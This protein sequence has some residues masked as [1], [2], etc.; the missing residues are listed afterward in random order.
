MEDGI[1]AAAVAV[2]GQL[3]LPRQAR[4]DLARPRE[5]SGMAVDVEPRLE[6][7]H[8]RVPVGIAQA[9][10]GVLAVGPAVGQLVG[11]IEGT[12]L[13]LEFR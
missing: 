4:A 7:D 11:R 3:G 1:L 13:R 9:I 2:E 10:R 6:L 5:R 12:Q 8:A